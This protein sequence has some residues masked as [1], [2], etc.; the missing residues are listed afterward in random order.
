MR[1]AIPMLTLSTCIRAQLASYKFR[2]S[3]YGIGE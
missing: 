1:P 3:V 2:L